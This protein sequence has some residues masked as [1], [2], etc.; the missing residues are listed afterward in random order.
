MGQL[1]V[2][3]VNC[4]SCREGI[5]V[6]PSTHSV[7]TCSHC[8]GSSL[9]VA[10][11]LCTCGRYAKRKH[12]KG[13]YCGRKECIEPPPP[14]VT[15]IKPAG[16]FAPGG[17]GIRHDR[18][19]SLDGIYIPHELVGDEEALASYIRDWHGV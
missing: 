14:V 10:D 4:P 7:G 12:D 1:R 19:L 6:N 18:P 13:F 3:A 11:R 16:S 8:G 17:Y 2:H 15:V 9:V 5:V